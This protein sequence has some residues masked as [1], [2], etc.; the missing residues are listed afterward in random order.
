MPADRRVPDRVCVARVGR[1]DGGG[2]P[3]DKILAKAVAQGLVPAW[4]VAGVVDIEVLD[5][6]YPVPG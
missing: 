1:D 5:V 2:L 3:Y 6:Q 4:H